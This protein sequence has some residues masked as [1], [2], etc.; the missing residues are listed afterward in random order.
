GISQLL[1]ENT[2]TLKGGYNYHATPY[3]AD[4]S[5]GV[6]QILFGDWSNAVLAYFGSIDIVVDPFSSKDTAQ[7]ELA[8]NRWADFD[9]RQVNGWAKEDG[10]AVS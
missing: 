3:M 10:V 5:S 7:V 4:A 8:M 6:G 9:L 1:N 2:R